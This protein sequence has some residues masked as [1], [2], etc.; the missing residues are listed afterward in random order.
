[1][2]EY[3]KFYEEEEEIENGHKEIVD[4]EVTPQPVKIPLEVQVVPASGSPEMPSL[5]PP[6]PP[7]GIPFPPQGSPLGDLPSFMGFCTMDDITDL[8]QWA[9]DARADRGILSQRVEE[10]SNS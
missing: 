2:E 8:K 4:G 7:P 1:M 10:L 5:S 9:V 6:T 3:E